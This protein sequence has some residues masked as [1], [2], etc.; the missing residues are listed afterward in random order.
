MP[1]ETPNLKYVHNFRTESTLNK[2]QV[3]RNLELKLANARNLYSS[4]I[5]EYRELEPQDRALFAKVCT[6][7]FLQLKCKLSLK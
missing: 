1:V 6:W 5:S 3:F 2:I 7:Y 4:F